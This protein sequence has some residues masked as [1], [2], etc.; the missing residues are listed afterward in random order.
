MVARWPES[1]EMLQPDL[2]YLIEICRVAV[3]KQCFDFDN[4]ISADMPCLI[5]SPNKTC[6]IEYS[7]SL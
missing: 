4:I 7:R 6:L 2:D 3:E 1:P 5:C